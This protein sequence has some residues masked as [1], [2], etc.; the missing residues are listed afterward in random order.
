[1]TSTLEEQVELLLD[2]YIVSE[3]TGVKVLNELV[4]IKE[5]S[6]ELANLIREREK[7]AYDKG[8]DEA[9]EGV[10]RAEKEQPK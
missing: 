4:Q 3:F 8:Y 2:K 6:K 1:M 5:F 9:L 10:L 7:A